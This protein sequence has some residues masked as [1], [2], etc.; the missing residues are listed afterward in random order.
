MKQETIRLIKSKLGNTGLKVSSLGLGGFHQC[1]V[2]S[3][4][5]GQVVDHFVALGGNYVE[6]ARSYGSGASETKLGQA[7][8]KHRRKLILASKTVKRDAEGAWRELNETLEALQTDHLDLYFFHGV[9]TFEDAGA[10]VAA[11]GSLEAFTRART[12]GMVKHFAISSHW[13]AILP[14]LAEIIPF[15]A[16]LI[17]GN[18]LDFCNYPEIPDEILPDLRSRGTGILFMKALADG[19]L[20]RSI[21]NAFRYSL[22]Y[23]P[24]C[25]VSGF[26]SVE[27]LDADAAVMAKGPLTD[28]ETELVLANAPELGNYVCRQCPN[29]S[30]LAGRKARLLKGLFELEGKYDRQM[31]DF[32][33]VDSGIY[34]L[35]QYLGKWFGNA[36][37]MESLFAENSA[38]FMEI[39]EP[40][41]A[42]DVN[43]EFAPCRYGID[44]SRKIRI[45]A[46]KLSGGQP[47]KI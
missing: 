20:Y 23:N 8:K 43:N 13:P 26:N 14:Q 7:I 31:F 1:E 17:W 36:Q 35:R 6:T 41:I 34:A 24:D 44:I 25:I 37:R 39:I 40:A 42:H 9:N 2:D 16:V 46:A 47:A 21:E 18:Y 28:A 19:Y 4:I 29:C 3:D 11:G 38:D 12:E 15:E 45:I 33:P 32:L 5:V 27:L 22:R 30:V 10:I